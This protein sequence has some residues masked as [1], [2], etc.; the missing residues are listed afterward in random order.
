MFTRALGLGIGA[1]VYYARE[2]QSGGRTHHIFTP[3]T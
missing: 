2:I 3:K 1:K